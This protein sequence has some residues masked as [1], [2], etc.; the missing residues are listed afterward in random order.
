LVIVSLILVLTL[1]NSLG[2]TLVITFISNRLLVLVIKL[3]LLLVI[4]WV[5]LL[6]L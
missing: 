1:V 2:L 4:L 5:S 3:G 6:L